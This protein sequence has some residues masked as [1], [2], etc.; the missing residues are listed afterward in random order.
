MWPE[1]TTAT[2]FGTP[3]VYVVRDDKDLLQ[4]DVLQTQIESNNLNG[5]III[6]L[7]SSLDNL[8]SFRSRIAFA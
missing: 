5:N 7:I 6:H 8:A 1:I 4:D 3:S 2:L